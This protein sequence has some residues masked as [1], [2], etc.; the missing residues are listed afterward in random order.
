M[1][2]TGYSKALFSTW[3]YCSDVKLLLDAGEG[4]NC[5]LGGRLAACRAVALTHG[6]T[7]H[8]TGLMNVIVT[9]ARM[10]RSA[11]HSP[12]PLSVYYPA[13]DEALCRYVDYLQSHFGATELD[14]LAVT[15][16]PVTE[17]QRY[18]LPSRRELLLVPFTVDHALN[19]AA[20]G[21]NLIEV[22]HKLRPE[23]Q[24]LKADGVAQA[25][26]ER[27]RDAVVH[28]VDHLLATYSGDTRRRPS[29][30][31]EEAEV[32]LHEATFFGREDAEAEKHAALEDVVSLAMQK[33]VKSLI[34]FHLS[35]RYR[36]EEVD[37][38][39]ARVASE[40]RPAFHI[41]V[42]RPG[43]L[44]RRIELPQCPS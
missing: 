23:L 3:I 36:W 8:F 34:L 17:G 7:D 37:A 12:E 24:H 33:R 19:V 30:P 6:H 15:W 16:V 43:E 31:C 28:P 18:T 2:F 27:G 1:V 22:R 14:E 5:S 25:I 20:M 39:V 11:T 41:E 4:V 35:A 38:E 40:R 10:N 44:V 9:R 29:M 21:Y 13:G 26:A 32:L 42:F